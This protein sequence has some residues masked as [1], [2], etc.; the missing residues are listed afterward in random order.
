MSNLSSAKYNYD[1]VV[2]TTQRS[3]NATM[4]IFLSSRS[5]PEVTVCYVANPKGEPQAIDYQTLINTTGAPDPFTI[6]DGANV[7]GDDRVKRLLSA[8]FMMAF[9]AKLGIPPMDDLTKVPDVVVLGQDTSAVQFNMLCSEFEVVRLDPGSGY[10]PPSWVHQAQPTNNPWIF[11][12]KVDL[13]LSLVSPTKFKTL[14]K[15]VQDQ[16]ANLGPNAFSI[17]QLLFDL[18]NATLSTVPTI[19]GVTPGT[20][21]YLILEQYFIGAYFTQMQKDGQ[22]LLGCS[23]VHHPS[24]APASLTLTSM[25]MEISPYVDTNGQAMPYPNSDQQDAATLSYLCATDGNVLPP[26]V[27]FSWNWVDTSQMSDHDGVLSIN[28]N[29]FANWIYHEVINDAS[30]CCLLPQVRCWQDGLT[31]WY[32]GTVAPNQVPTVTRPSNG[33]NVLQLSYSQSGSDQAG[34]GGALGSI[35]MR[36]SY[37]L[38]ISFSGNTIVATQSLLVYVKITEAFIHDDGNIVDKSITD[39]YTIGIDANGRLTSSQPVTTNTDN[40][41]AITEGSFANFFTNM[42]EIAGNIKNSVDNFVATSFADLPI[43]TIQ[44]FV[45]PGGQTFTFKEIGF[46]PNQDLVSEISYVD[47]AIPPVTVPATTLPGSAG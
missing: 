4:L 31:T 35:T 18:S 24:Q 47:P 11:S 10:G 12:S 9:R 42:N 8:R 39:T 38:S 27:P 37:S 19:T 46:S 29:T 25:N 5:E 45:F 6:E 26:A 33:N 22:P 20:T 21:T 3:I 34:A 44:D 43:S 1:F 30:R 28:R 36:S 17:Q 7:Q 32:S 16:I 13:R 14:P 15:N 41:I 23:V 40:S 2:A